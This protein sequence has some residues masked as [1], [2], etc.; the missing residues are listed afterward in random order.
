MSE[1]F[2][3][4]IGTKDEELET[5][6]VNHEAAEYEMFGAKDE[7]NQSEDKEESSDDEPCACILCSL[8]N[9]KEPC[10]EK[11]DEPPCNEEEDELP[12]DHK[13]DQPCN[14]F[15][16]RS[17]IQAI[18]NFSLVMLLKEETLI[19][20]TH[21]AE[22][23]GMIQENSLK[24]GREKPDDKLHVPNFYLAMKKAWKIWK[25]KGDG[26]KETAFEAFYTTL[27]KQEEPILCKD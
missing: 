25:K 14:C 16:C 4:F 22:F 21:L 17:P 26:Y 1:H 6:Q 5:E 27:T 19:L 23:R 15:M 7:E 20:Q 10:N 18:V 24:M 13:K 3:S 8:D 11:E 9:K 2:L 12:R